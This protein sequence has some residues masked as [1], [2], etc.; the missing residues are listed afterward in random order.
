MAPSRSTVGSVVG[1]TSTAIPFESIEERCLYGAL[2]CLESYYN[3]KPPTGQKTLNHTL[4]IINK[5]VEK[6][7]TIQN[8][9]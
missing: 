3:R 4:S 8:V 6:T 7:T 5:C 2:L 9:R 1:S